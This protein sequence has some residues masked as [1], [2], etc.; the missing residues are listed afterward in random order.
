MRNKIQIKSTGNKKSEFGGKIPLIILL[1]LMGGIFFVVY[2]TSSDTAIINPTSSAPEMATVVNQTK[3]NSKIGP[4]N[5]HPIM[6]NVIGG[7]SGTIENGNLYFVQPKP[8][9]NA[10]LWTQVELVNRGEIDLKY[11]SFSENFAVY[12]ATTSNPDG[13][14]NNSNWVKV[15][16]ENAFITLSGTPA[17]FEVKSSY[18]DSD[19][20]LVVALENGNYYAKENYESYPGPVHFLSVEKG[21]Y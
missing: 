13:W 5:D 7:S 21:G 8:Q 19:Y 6:E 3:E 14:T 15:P 4:Y 1:L 11:T 16:K 18:V 12:Q 20:P 9:Y 17:T 2:A 10:G